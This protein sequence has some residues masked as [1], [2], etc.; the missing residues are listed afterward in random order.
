MHLKVM[1]CCAAGHSE[2]E[3]VRDDPETD[4]FNVQ[5]MVDVF[6][7]KAQEWQKYVQGEQHQVPTFRCLV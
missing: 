4:D 6:V 5:A 1:Y 2:T 7:T 3:A